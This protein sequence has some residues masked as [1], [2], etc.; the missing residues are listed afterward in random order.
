[1]PNSERKV[2]V[3]AKG[4]GVGTE[5]N[6][7]DLDFPTYSV[8]AWNPDK[9]RAIIE[10]SASNCDPYAP[11]RTIV[12]SWVPD[13]SMKCIVYD[14]ACKIPWNRIIQEKYRE[15]NSRWNSE[16]AISR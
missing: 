13:G 11:T 3:Y 14:D 15:G 16:D 9:S 8:V 1:M 10:V 6:P 12:G 7:H 4:K 5:R 2:N